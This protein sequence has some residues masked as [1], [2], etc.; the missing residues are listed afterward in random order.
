M[1]KMKNKKLKLI[2]TIVGS[3]VNA[4]LAVLKLYV[5]LIS[6][7]I[8]ILAD[9][10]NNFCDTFGFIGASIGIAVSD[11]K[12]TDKFP[13]GFG[14]TEHV[15]S[16]LISVLILVIGGL[17]CYQSLERVFMPLPITFNWLHFG[18]IAATI[19][20]K[21]GLAVFLWWVDKKS[22]SPI[23]K[24]EK[25]DCILDASITATTLLGFGISKYTSI[26]VDG[27]FG[28]AI[29]VIIVVVG[30]KLAAKSFGNLIDKKDEATYDSLC[31]LFKTYGYADVDVKIFGFG[32]EKY[33]VAVIGEIDE[34][35]DL[36]IKSEAKEKLN[37]TLYIDTGNNLLTEQ[38][39]EQNNKNDKG[40]NYGE[41]E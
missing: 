6:N 4:A 25:L 17:F 15:V 41:K 10:I 22:D 2:S 5:G 39:T 27:I 20:V 9:G 23:V 21:I 40:E 37:L 28:V 24:I 3:V 33:A 16:L 18:L 1:S 29:A 7:S 8:S 36:A 14:K 32:S 35:K 31:E 38:I 30:V 34:D 13:Y 19:P 12:P 11:K 26:S